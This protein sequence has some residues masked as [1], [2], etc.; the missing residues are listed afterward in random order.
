MLITLTAVSGL[1]I[2]V[3]VSWVAMS[4]AKAMERCRRLVLPISSVPQSLVTI[5][6]VSHQLEAQRVISCATPNDP[7]QA[8][9]ACGASACNRRVRLGEQMSFTCAAKNGGRM[10]CN[11]GSR[12]PLEC[13]RNSHMIGKRPN[14][15]TS[16]PAHSPREGRPG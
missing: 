5:W 6:W 9:A 16:G 3:L 15:N 12:L 13:I 14:Q 7:V 4:E 10:I 1:G 11:S 2:F 8:R